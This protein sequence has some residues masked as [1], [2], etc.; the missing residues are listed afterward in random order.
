VE[1][2]VLTLWKQCIEF[3]LNFQ[4]CPGSKICMWIS[5]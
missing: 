3:K 4:P 1:K 5:L 2:P